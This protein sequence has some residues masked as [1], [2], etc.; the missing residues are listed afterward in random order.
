MTTMR[1]I[2]VATL[3]LVVGVW[4]T[5]VATATAAT[6]SCGTHSIDLTGVRL[7]ND[8]VSVQAGPFDFAL[9][10]GTY[11][12]TMLSNDNHPHESYQ[13]GQ[14]L[15]Q[16]YFTLDSGYRSPPSV[17]IPSSETRTTT[18]FSAVTLAEAS[19]ISV[20]H[21]GL[22]GVNSVNVEC[23]GFTPTPVATTTTTT[24]PQIL[25]PETVP[26][27]PVPV[28]VAPVVEQAEPVELAITGGT[29]LPT[30]VVGLALIVVGFALALT[31]KRMG[32]PTW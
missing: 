21:L 24:T 8:G 27:P 31:G 19:A 15:E 25:S 10:A 14:T 30:I 3:T 16:W 4:F 13:T 12:I 9:P 28:E 6:G 1:R 2:S 22:E 5:G 18:Q 32:D 23:I 26:D 29:A 7:I 20:H 17:D 11:D